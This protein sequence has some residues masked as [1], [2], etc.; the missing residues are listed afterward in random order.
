MQQMRPFSQ[1]TMI[2]SSGSEMN[3]EMVV[4]RMIVH[5]NAQFFNLNYRPVNYV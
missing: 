1:G 4:W 3:M 2:D 5:E